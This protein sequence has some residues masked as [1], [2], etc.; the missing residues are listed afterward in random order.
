VYLTGARHS[1]DGRAVSTPR[2]FQAYGRNYS[3]SGQTA[4]ATSWDGAPAALAG[5]RRIAGLLVAPTVPSTGSADRAVVAVPNGCLCNWYEPHHSIGMHRDDT[6][7]LVH[8]APIYSISWGH[9]RKFVLEP[10]IPATAAAASGTSAE[11]LSLLLGDG[12]LLVMGG[13]CQSTHKHSIPRIDKAAVRSAECTPPHLGRRISFTF[14]SFAEMDT[15]PTS[16]TV[17]NQ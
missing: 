16:S 6:R 15:R 12:D 3:F 14:R 11:P 8:C 13:R 4:A 1:S 9:P 2:Y 10:R 5:L 7:E 17:A